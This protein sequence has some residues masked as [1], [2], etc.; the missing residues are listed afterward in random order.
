M[1]IVNWAKCLVAVECIYCI[2]VVFPKL[3]ILSL[4]LRIFTTKP[5]RTAAYVLAGLLTANGI[6]G[7][8]TSL[9][10]C[11]P[12]PARWNPTLTGA[13]CIQVDPFWRWISFINI[14]TD[15]VMLG[16]PLPVIWN[17]HTSRNQKVGLTFVFLTGSLYVPLLFLM[18]FYVSQ[19]SASNR[20]PTHSAADL[21][22]RLFV[23]QF[24]SI[25]MASSTALGHLQL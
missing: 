9:V 2:A 22:L 20:S 10:S 4:Y 23:S 1:A 16:L 3:F 18:L 8:A 17:L 15:V 12:L 25:P 7:I 19:S 13:K 11:V 24:F 6:A 5:Y 21:H 14:F